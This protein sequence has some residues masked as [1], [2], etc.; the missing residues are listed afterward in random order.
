MTRKHPAGP[1]GGCR[2]RV[3]ATRLVVLR[4]LSDQH[5]DRH[6]QLAGPGVVAAV[7]G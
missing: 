5:R 1:V 6:H 2:L 4:D 7:F 3:V